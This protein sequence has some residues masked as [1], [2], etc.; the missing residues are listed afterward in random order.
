MCSCCKKGYSGCIRRSFTDR[1]RKL[2]LPFY[3]EL[4]RL[5]LECCGQF[6]TPQHKKIQPYCIEFEK[7]PLKCWRHWGMSLWQKTE[8]PGSVE[9][10]QKKPQWEFYQWIW[11]SEEWCKEDRARFFSIAPSDKGNRHKVKY[12]KSYLNIK[13]HFHCKCHWALEQ[14]AKGGCNAC[15]SLC[16][17]SK[18]ICTLSWTTSLRL[19]AGG[20]DQM[21]SRH[22]F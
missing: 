11:I 21:T 22:S 1:L 5:H 20:L 2:I 15:I 13:Q 17:Y 4:V 10:E 6:R 19:V 9:P 8:K 12:I 18:S 3:S 7:G 16:R 14:L